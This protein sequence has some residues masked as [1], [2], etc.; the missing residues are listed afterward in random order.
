M[1]MQVANLLVDVATYHAE[2]LAEHGDTP[3]GVDWS[4]EESQVVR[5]AQSCK[6]R[7]SRQVELLDD[8]GSYDLTILVR[9][10]PC[11]NRL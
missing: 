3:R 7:Y 8:Y 2:K 1:R 6:R 5:F 4:G 10:M 11:E 9:K